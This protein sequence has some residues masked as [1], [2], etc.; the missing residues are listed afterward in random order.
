MIC[1]YKKGQLCKEMTDLF[2]FFLTEKGDT[3]AVEP[4]QINFVTR[5]CFL[6][7]A[8][9]T[10]RSNQTHPHS[11]SFLSPHIY[12]LSRFFGF[13]LCSHPISHVALFWQHHSFAQFNLVNIESTIEFPSC[14][15]EQTFKVIKQTNWKSDNLLLTNHCRWLRVWVL[16]LPSETVYRCSPWSTQ[17]WSAPSRGRCCWWGQSFSFPGSA[18]ICLKVGAYWEGTWMAREDVDCV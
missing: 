8:V 13:R 17:V 15:K 7:S 12:S 5:W 6:P 14:G 11:S 18:P 3:A 10:V 2:S 1:R 4:H 16:H 9:A